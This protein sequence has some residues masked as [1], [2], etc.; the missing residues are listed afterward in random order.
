MYHDAFNPNKEEVEDLKRRYLKGKVGD[1]EVK[2]KLIIALNN[3]LEPI[4]KRRA[5]YENN[6]NE[7][8]DILADGTRVTRIEAQKTL[9]AVREAMKMDYF[10]K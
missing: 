4:R 10:K 6:I 3:F 7:V 5:Y 1:I 8:M 9:V 2:E